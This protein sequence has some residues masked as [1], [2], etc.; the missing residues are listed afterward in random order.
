[1]LSVFERPLRDRLRDTF[2]Q[3]AIG[4]TGGGAEGL[5]ETTK[6]LGPALRDIAIDAQALRGT[7]GPRRLEAGR[8]GKFASP[9]RWR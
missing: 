8:V 4:L 5:R 3:L 7:E 6:N 2:G 1:M 9:P